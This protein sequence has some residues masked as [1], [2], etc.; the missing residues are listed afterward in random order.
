MLN[1]LPDEVEALDESSD[2]QSSESSSETGMFNW[3]VTF[4][5]EAL[6]SSELVIS[7]DH[8]LPKPER[9]GLTSGFLAGTGGEVGVTIHESIIRVL[10]V[11]CTGGMMGVLGEI[12]PREAGFLP[13][14][15]GWREMGVR[16]RVWRM[17]G[18]RKTT[19]IP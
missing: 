10:Q 9:Q 3:K 8:P 18:P 2:T 1:A 6:G 7:Q 14:W 11:R 19:T 17:R 13:T 5:S 4:E 15:M 12:F 16:G